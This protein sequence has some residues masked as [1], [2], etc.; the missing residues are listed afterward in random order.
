MLNH[1]SFEIII[2]ICK[3]SIVR[4]YRKTGTKKEHFF[5]SIWCILLIEI[6]KC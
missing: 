6:C 1:F 5:Y 3:M 2:L 4:T